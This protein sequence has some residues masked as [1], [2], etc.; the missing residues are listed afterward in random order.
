MKTS[1]RNRKTPTPT[2]GE[3]VERPSNILRLYSDGFQEISQW[4]QA[5]RPPYTIQDIIRFNALYKRGYPVL[6]R[7][8]KRR[9]EEWVDTLI[10]GVEDRTLIP[11]IFGVV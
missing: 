9:V 6:S 1:T 2:S 11:K 10:E 3:A 5:S 8:E 4:F 7:E